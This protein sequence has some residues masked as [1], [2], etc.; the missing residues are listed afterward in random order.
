MREFAGAFAI[1]GGAMAT[2]AVPKVH[3]NFIKGEGVEARTG[4]AFED[5]NPAHASELIG[6]F[7]SSSQED[8]DDAVD[9]AQEAFKKWRVAPAPPRAE[10]LYRVAETLASPNG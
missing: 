5:R 8:V 3:K 4:R 7:P 6:I 9:A 10:V 2:V 1:A